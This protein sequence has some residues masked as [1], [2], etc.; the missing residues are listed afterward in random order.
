MKFNTTDDV[1]HK[2]MSFAL[3]TAEN[4]T[5]YQTSNVL[6]VNQYNNNDNDI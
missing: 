6:V 2:E 3:F 5:D 1:K 4:S